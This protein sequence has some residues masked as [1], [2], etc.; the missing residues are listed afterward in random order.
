MDD[1]TRRW[2]R[3]IPTLIAVVGLIVTLIFNTVG[4]WQQVA[5]TKRE[6]ITAE[7]GLI[8]QLSGV[9]RQAE[10][11]LV[12]VRT[13]ACSGRQPNQEH[14]EALL[15]A[16]QEYD[17]LAWLFNQRHIKMESAR[18]YWAPSIIETFE[19]FATIQYADARSR[20]PNLEEF[21]SDTPKQQWPPGPC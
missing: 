8:T 21:R 18:R 17:Y 19:L 7:L 20:V 16:A 15:E 3:N 1:A 2:W 11:R 4:V 5:Q 10:A 14:K 9:A 13:R 12:A 6:R